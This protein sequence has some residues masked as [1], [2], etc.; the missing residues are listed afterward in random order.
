MYRTVA[1]RLV[2]TAGFTVVSETTPETVQRSANDSDRRVVDLGAGTEPD[3]RA[4]MA[5]DVAQ[6]SGLDLRFDLDTHP[7]PLADAS[8][9]G[10]VASHVVE[11][12]DDVEGVLRE[13]TRVLKPGGWLEI[14]VP[15][16]RPNQTDPTHSNTWTWTT[17]EFFARGGT[18]DYYFDLPLVLEDREMTVWLEG[19]FS[20][21]SPL[22]RAFVS[23]YGPDDWVSGTPYMAGTL[24]VR[25]RRAER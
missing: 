16:G 9:D 7:W 20:K 25:F 23:L 18:R 6:L 10:I 12:L 15:L 21:V 22:Y 4:T 2:S 8:L 3:P 5:A 17:P 14:D 11:H 24:T 13:V 19:P 1:R